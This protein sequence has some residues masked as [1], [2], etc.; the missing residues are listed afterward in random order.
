MLVKSMPRII[1]LTNPWRPP[2]E[3]R[4]LSRF[5]LL[6]HGDQHCIASYIAFYDS[7]SYTTNLPPRAL[8]YHSRAYQY[9]PQA[10]SCPAHDFGLSV[11]KAPASAHDKRTGWQRASRLSSLCPL[12]VPIFSQPSSHTRLL[13]QRFESP[14]TE[15]FARSSPL[16]FSSSSSPPLSSTAT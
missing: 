1:G 13:P 5:A 6:R 9:R 3:A 10:A 12:Y 16:A 11:I 2:A 8:C 14:L 7:I 15:N 4:N